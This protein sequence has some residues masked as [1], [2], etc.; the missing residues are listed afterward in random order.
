VAVAAVAALA[1][2]TQDRPSGIGT[3]AE[4]AVG[5]AR[6]APAGHRD[7][8]LAAA[9]W[10]AQ[11]RGD[12]QAS[13]SYAEEALAAGYP[14]DSP[15]PG[16]A[17]LQAVTAYTYLGRRGE[18]QDALLH[19]FDTLDRP[20]THPYHRANLRMARVATGM[21]IDDPAAEIEEARTALRLAEE[22]GS[23]SM[24]SYTSYAVG[25]ALRYEDP[26]GA[27]AA[28]DRCT[29]LSRQLRSGF[30]LPLALSFGAAIKAKQGLASEAL[31][32]MLAGL[33]KSALDADWPF[34]AGGLDSAVDMFSALGEW[35]T[36]AVL[37]AALETPSLLPIRYP[38]VSQLGPGLKARTEVL[39]RV[40]SE[41]GEE[42]YEQAAHLGRSM[43]REDVLAFA[44]DRVRSRLEAM[45]A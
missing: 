43:G 1:Y 39:G 13:V 2:E 3:W 33:E 14:P 23:L 4:R 8:V 20:T 10:A 45:P 9:S 18:A 7:A 31:A 11:I 42:V 15:A 5:A 32:D 6:S 27:I 35:R 29:A 25:W 40:R 19:A 21:L 37:A 30:L 41:L 38:P 34:I 24:L 26:D 17:A 44:L 22:A 16:V 28:Y 12:M 36:A